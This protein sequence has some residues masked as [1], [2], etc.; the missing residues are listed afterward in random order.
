LRPLLTT[1]NAHLANEADICPYLAAADVMIADH[2]SAAF[3]YLLRDRP[4][5]RFHAPALIALANIHPDYVALLE[6]A[7]RS[8]VDIDGAIAEVERAISDPAALSATRR[9]VAADLFYEPG[10]AT[11]RCAAALYEAVGLEPERVP[12]HRAADTQG[13]RAEQTNSTG[14]ASGASGHPADIWQPSA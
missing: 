7:S 2:S 13:T 6:S 11:A 9:A 1:S 5:V 14:A 12:E 10:T 4:I 3:E 8:V